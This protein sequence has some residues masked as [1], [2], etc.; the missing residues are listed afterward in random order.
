MHLNEEVEVIKVILSFFFFLS[1][2]LLSIFLL[3][4]G[5]SNLE[6]QDAGDL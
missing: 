3:L 1:L 2:T 5:K 4:C 6:P